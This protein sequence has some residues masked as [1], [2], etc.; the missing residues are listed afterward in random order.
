[1]LDADVERVAHALEDLPED[2]RKRPDPA[3]LTELASQ[4]GYRATINLCAEMPQGDDPA[5]AQA[6]LSGVLTT[7][8]VPITDMETPTIKQ[9]TQILDLLS[10][11][12]AETTYVHCEAGRGRTGAVIAC[13]RMGEWWLLC[14]C[15]LNRFC[16]RVHCSLP[17]VPS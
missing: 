14:N 16:W 9:L 5:I 1:M 4:Q 2:A 10:D 7:T 3:K 13:Y 8:H 6:G 11:P 15:V 17:L 12:A